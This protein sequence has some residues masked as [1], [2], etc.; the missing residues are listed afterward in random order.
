MASTTPELPLHVEK[1]E[2]EVAPGDFQTTA[3]PIHPK[4]TSM[5]LAERIALYDAET[6]VSRRTP[7][8]STAT[9][10]LPSSRNAGMSL[11]E[12]LA[13][14]DAG[15]VTSAKPSYS[16]HVGS[17]VGHFQPATSKSD[18]KE[19]STSAAVFGRI[20]IYQNSQHVCIMISPFAGDYR[21]AE[22]TLDL[23]KPR[24]PS[25]ACTSDH[26]ESVKLSENTHTQHSFEAKIRELVSSG[27]RRCF[28]SSCKAEKIDAFIAG[29]S[30]L[31][32]AWSYG[33]SVESALIAQ[34][35][36]HGFNIS[37]EPNTTLC[38]IL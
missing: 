7:S 11:T 26:Y 2:N 34:A 37:L 22:Y 20:S 18:S 36:K 29:L 5:S 3:L 33:E 13:Q 10:S 6:V 17:K 28:F 4:K 19:P 12:K 1:P 24:G 21:Y 25:V 9:V 30:A 38:L 27:Y 31:N 35:A 8:S 15:T 32:D 23:G 16:A 14:Y